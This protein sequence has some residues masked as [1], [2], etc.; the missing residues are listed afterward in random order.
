M[1]GCIQCGIKKERWSKKYCSN[2][3]Q[4]Q[5]QYEEYIAHW[6]QGKVVQTKNISRYLKRFL[7]EKYEERCSVC[8]WDKKHPLTHNVPLEVDHI[9]GNSGNN[10]GSNLRLICANCHSLTI[11]FKNFNKGKGRKWRIAQIEIRKK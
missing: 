11:N 8:G 3:C 7:I 2:V 5:Y 4:W 1:K 9:D 10:I 6:K